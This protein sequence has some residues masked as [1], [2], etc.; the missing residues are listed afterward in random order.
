MNDRA[1]LKTCPLFAG[2]TEAD[3]DSLTAVCRQREV[4]KGEVL[5]SQG[6]RAVGFYLVAEGKVKIYKLS[7]DGKERILHIVH[8]GESF[9]EAAIFW[10]MRNSFPMWAL[11]NGV[12]TIM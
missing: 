8:P 10:L 9:A 5:F 2:V 1:A 3:L 7:A 11:G 6:E 4:A 12:L